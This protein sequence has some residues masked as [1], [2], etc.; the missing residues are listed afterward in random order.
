MAFCPLSAPP[1]D[2]QITTMDGVAVARQSRVNLV[3]LAGSER[4]KTSKS[5]GLQ[6][7]E[8]AAINKSLSTLGRVISAVVKMQ[9]HKS[10]QAQ[11]I[12]YR[13]SLLTWLLSESFGGNARTVMMATVSPSP[14]NFE[15][16]LSTLRY[17]PPSPQQHTL[18]SHTRTHTLSTPTPT[19]SCAYMI[20]CVL[21]AR[22]SRPALSDTPLVP[23]R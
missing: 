16:T 5:T 1:R 19:L 18:S 3:D 6:L 13:S 12:P 7:K 17:P 2:V 15:E 10:D 11:H 20:D 23:E 22:G 9:G 21:T 4:Q 14:E 8:G